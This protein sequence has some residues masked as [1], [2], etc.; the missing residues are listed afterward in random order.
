M[1]AFE[2]KYVKALT[3]NRILEYVTEYD[4]IDPTASTGYREFILILRKVVGTRI[5][6]LLTDDIIDS[7]FDL[8]NTYSN[9]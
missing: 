6:E 5:F 2:R 4:Q 9:Q 8:V 3:P 7:T 1:R